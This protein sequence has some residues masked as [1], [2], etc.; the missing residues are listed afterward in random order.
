MSPVVLIR[1]LLA[2]TTGHAP[3]PEPDVV[4]RFSAIRDDV[5]S[6][7]EAPNKEEQAADDKW[8]PIWTERVRAKKRATPRLKNVAVIALP[9]TESPTV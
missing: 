1:S 6:K 2:G 9:E 5:P 3:A 8:T 7:D 4:R